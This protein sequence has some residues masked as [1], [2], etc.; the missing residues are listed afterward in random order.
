MQLSLWFL[1]L[2]FDCGFPT[3]SDISLYLYTVKYHTYALYLAVNDF[4]CRMYMSSAFHQIRSAPPKCIYMYIDVVTSLHSRQHSS[5]RN[6]IKNSV[7]VA[8]YA[9]QCLRSCLPFFPIYFSSHSIIHLSSS[10][11]NHT[12]ANHD[13]PSQTMNN[14]SLTKQHSMDVANN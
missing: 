4:V 12:A 8:I 13:M 6:T 7:C 5:I 9:I 3:Q 11:Q 1:Q 10:R 2:I 14:H